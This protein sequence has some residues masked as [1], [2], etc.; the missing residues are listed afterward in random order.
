MIF[1]INMNP[2]KV[3]FKY[4]DEIVWSAIACGVYVLLRYAFYYYAKTCGFYPTGLLSY[5]SYYQYVF[6]EELFREG[7]YFWFRN[8]FGTLDQD[9]GLFNLY[10]TFLRALRPIYRFDLFLFDI[11]SGAVFLFGGTYFLL[12]LIGPLNWKEKAILLLGG[13]FGWIFHFCGLLPK[14]KLLMASFWGLNYLTNQIQTPEIVYHF[15]VFWGMYNLVNRK[16]LLVF[17]VSFFLSF[18]HPFNAVI[19]NVGVFFFGVAGVFTEKCQKK[20]C[21]CYCLISVFTTA[22]SFLVYNVFLPYASKDA[23]F[24]KN[25]YKV[26][27]FIEPDIYFSF[28]GVALLCFIASLSLKAATKGGLKGVRWT[29]Y[30]PQ[31][32]SML[33]VTLF[34][35]IMNMSYLI[36]NWI[37][38]P[39]HWS[40]VYPY[41]FLIGLSAMIIRYEKNERNKIYSITLWGLLLIA[42]ID[43]TLGASH[44][45]KFLVNDAR[46]P[47]LLSRDER[48]AITQL[49]NLSPGKVVYIRSCSSRKVAGDLE[50]AISALTTHKTPYG[51]FFFSPYYRQWA[52][53]TRACGQNNNLVKEILQ[54]MDY[55]I[56]DRSVIDDVGYAGGKKIWQGKDL[57][58]LSLN[59]AGDKK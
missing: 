10:A 13:G 3:A 20:E 47:A 5:D 16:T 12:R 50:Y 18:L 21:Y 31:A 25:A 24:Y 17:F 30:G 44:V 15:F 4:R 1:I 56:V 14:D 55:L 19:F 45:S 40:R 39:A 33:G 9:S 35:V 11:A 7:N 34:C 42:I 52:Y 41:V 27:F 53:L 48:D 58:L 43:S 57:V 29:I 8:P 36:S 6:S 51:H 32:F 46:P 2:F 59:S 54:R 23:A 28:L 26:P 22:L 37:V 49:R 38:Q